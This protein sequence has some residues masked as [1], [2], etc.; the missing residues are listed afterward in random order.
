MPPP[1]L[2]P[3]VNDKLFPPRR[4][5]IVLFPSFFSGVLKN[6][7]YVFFYQ[8]LS[9]NLFFFGGGGSLQ[10]CVFND[11]PFHTMIQLSETLPSHFFKNLGLQTIKGPGL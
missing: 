2:A 11:I 8:Y 5:P 3:S 7:N 10:K 1:P 6:P 9:L 4:I